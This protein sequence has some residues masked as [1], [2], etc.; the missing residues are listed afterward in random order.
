M[1]HLFIFSVPTA[2]L[3][4]SFTLSLT[5]AADT[6]PAST[7]FL[8][9]PLDFLSKLDWVRPKFSSTV[10]ITGPASILRTV[11]NKVAASRSFGPLFKIL[12]SFQIPTK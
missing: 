8:Q 6:C 9:A 2:P 10:T 4:F 11:R 7:S 12:E 3:L 5:K 1:Q